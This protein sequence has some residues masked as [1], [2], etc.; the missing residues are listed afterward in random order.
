VE[1]KSIKISTSEYR[2][3]CEVLLEHLKLSGLTGAVLF[4]NYY[5]LYY[6]GFAFI[7][8]ERPV[9]FVMNTKG[10]KALFVPR[11][12]VEHAQANAVVERVAQYVEYPFEP[13]PR[14]PGWLSVDSWI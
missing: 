7:P 11:L 5:I 13:H 12:E 10:E 9:A 14:R 3:R 2:A 6:A 4:E 8:T 1:P